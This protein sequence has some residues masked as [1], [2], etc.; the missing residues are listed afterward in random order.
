M[1]WPVYLVWPDVAIDRSTEC[2]A[3]QYPAMKKIT[4][5]RTNTD[6][7]MYIRSPQSKFIDNM[8]PYIRVCIYI[9]RN[10]LSHLEM[11]IFLEC[12]LLRTTLNLKDTI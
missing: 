10:V 8:K 5:T 4:N 7:L 9:K 1:T 6:R 11:H 2:T 3:D 12:L